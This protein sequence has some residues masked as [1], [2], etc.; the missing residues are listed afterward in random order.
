MMKNRQ[1]LQFVWL[2]I[3]AL[4]IV[5]GDDFPGFADPPPATEEQ[6]QGLPAPEVEEPRLEEFAPPGAKIPQ[7][8]MP[9]G[10]KTTEAE[11]EPEVPELKGFRDLL[12]EYG[13]FLKL[14]RLTDGRAFDPHAI[15]NHFLSRVVDRLPGVSMLKVRPSGDRAAAVATAENDL[16]LRLIYRVVTLPLVNAEKWAR[17]KQPLKEIAKK[18]GEHRGNFYHL[19]GHVRSVERIEPA[20]R[21]AKRFQLREYFRCG[22]MLRELDDE[23][24]F[25]LVPAVVYAGSVPKDWLEKESLDEWVS[26]NGVF[27]RLGAPGAVQQPDDASAEMKSARP[28]V[29]VAK[30]IAWHPPMLLALLGFDMGLF[31]YVQHGKQLGER[32]DNS[33][34]E[35]L[36][37]DR[38]NECFYQ[39]LHTAGKVSSAE[40]ITGAWKKVVV[41]GR[42]KV[43][44]RNELTQ[45]HEELLEKIGRLSRGSAELAAAKAKFEKTE[46]DLKTLK[47]QIERAKKLESELIPLILNPEENEGKLVLLRGVA[48]SIQWIW[49]TDKNT[50]ERFGFDHYYQIDMIVNLETDVTLSESGPEKKKVWSWPVTFC[51]RSLPK[52]LKVGVKIH[53]EVRIAG[54]FFKKWAYP[55][56]DTK[57]ERNVRRFAPMF[58]GRQPRLIPPVPPPETY[59]TGMVAGGLFLL[60]LLGIWLGVWRYSRDDQ[61]FHQKTIARS[62]MLQEGI[63]LNDLDLEVEDEPDFSNWN[64]APAETPPDASPAESTKPDAPADPPATD[65]PAD[66]PTDASPAESPAL[67]SSTDS[68]KPDAPADAPADDPHPDSR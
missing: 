62:H 35:M 48:R 45:Q 36:R 24:N 22:L 61:V 29:F 51:V 26:L 60:T 28:L 58:I 47:Y 5:A 52:N 33:F 4:V 54:F 50:K 38:E 1:P 27:V 18:P 67:D 68:I 65:S 16:L 44:R 63:S 46:Q 17:P 43:A 56:T 41:E 19:E 10:S 40:L 23:G 21:D 3:A 32:K 57:T 59:V 66:S 34:A 39:M 25:V 20:P 15:E 30:R 9:G 49:V 42:R 11:P 2:F 53:E 13:D 31:D 8:E 7:L 37:A 12:K 55:A 6:Q 64:T 14:N